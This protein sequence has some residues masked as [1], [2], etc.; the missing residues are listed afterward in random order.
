MKTCI[1][2]ALVF[3]AGAAR[4][5]EGERARTLEDF[6]I[7]AVVASITNAM[8]E[9]ARNYYLPDKPENAKKIKAYRKD[10]KYYLSHNGPFRQAI[11][12]ISINLAKA[13]ARAANRE[14]ETLPG[15]P[16]E[17][18]PQKP[19]YE[20][21]V[22]SITVT[23]GEPMMVYTN[24]MP[25]I[26]AAGK[27]LHGGVREQYLPGAAENSPGRRYYGREAAGLMSADRFFNHVLS[28]ACAKLVQL[29]KMDSEEKKR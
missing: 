20:E 16:L 19:D 2:A 13:G 25:C 26:N 21:G 8:A 6:D 3:C 1:M 9:A 22:S 5:G 14:Y 28:E 29:A 12:D 15:T 7:D 24:T 23:G 4:A 10:A 17:L 11:G 27:A 18:P